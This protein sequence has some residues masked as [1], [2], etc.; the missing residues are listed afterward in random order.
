V[1]TRVVHVASG[2]EWR[3]GQRQVWLLARELARLD[4]IEQ[5]VVT[6]P[7]T[8]LARRLRLDDIP[9]HEVPWS[10]GLDLRVVPA[11]VAEARGHSAVLHAHD[12]HATTLAGIASW[13]SGAPF[14]TTRRVDFPLRHP[15]MWKRARRVIA[16]SQAVADVLAEGG[17]APDR[18]TI[19][20][21]GIAID[22]ARATTPMGIRHRL[23]LA[24]DAMVAANV[25]SLVGHKDHATLLRTAAVLQQSLPGVHWVVAGDGPLRRT[26][27]ELRAHLGLGPRVHFLGHVPDPVGLIADADVFVMSSSQEGLGTSVLDAMA[28]GTPVA[29]TAAGGLPDLL[30]DGAGLLVPT[31]DFS[32][33]ADAVRRILEDATLRAT[34]ISR[35]AAVVQRFT[36]RRMAEDAVS[37]Y[38]SCASFP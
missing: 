29:S 2:R 10:A 36:S 14:V 21:S 26:M 28:C 38:R 15:A 9:I 31:G 37:V 6:G 16:I 13:I 27:E 30:G 5:V 33:L 4:G 18:I 32:A 7:R 8:D 19:I 12:A 34:L 25:A 17:V 23:G 20:P 22:E 24:P 11:V 3:G 1:T 35:A